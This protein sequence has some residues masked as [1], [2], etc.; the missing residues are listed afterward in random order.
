MPKATISFLDR[1]YSYIKMLSAVLDTSMAQ[2]IN[3]VLEYI[4][5]NVDEEDI[6]DN[7]DE[8]FKD[9]KATL[10]ETEE[11]EEEGEED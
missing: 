5:D 4:K 2:V 10:E 11:E 6:W 3:D 8:L 7:W 9:F 1:P